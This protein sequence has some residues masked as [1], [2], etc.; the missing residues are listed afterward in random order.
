MALR[1]FKF[2]IFISLVIMA[3]GSILH[4]AHMMHS[5]MQLDHCPYTAQS[6]VACIQN[7][8]LQ[9]I[10]SHQLA[11]TGSLGAVGIILLALF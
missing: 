1:L 5:D 4:T 8:G 3:S 9:I 10:D 6:E 7:A 11:G 2:V